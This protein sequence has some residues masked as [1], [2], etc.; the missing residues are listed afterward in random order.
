MPCDFDIDAAF[1]LSIMTDSDALNEIA[2]GP[3][4]VRLTLS[5]ILLDCFPQTLQLALVVGKE[6]RMQRDDVRCV[7]H[8]KFGLEP[9]GSMA[10][11]CSGANALARPI[12][13]RMPVLL[14][15]AGI[16]HWLNRTGDAELL[17]PASDDRLRMWPAS[18]R[19]DKTG[20][21]DDDTTL[22][23]QAAA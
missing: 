23:N 15:K 13:D 16:W 3:R 12:H 9:L 17:R 2:N 19:V 4:V 7:R 10:G 22:I 20:T 11:S 14:D 6:A 8:G 5:N 21:G 1:P 18:R